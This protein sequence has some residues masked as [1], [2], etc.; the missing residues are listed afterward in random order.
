MHRSRI[1]RTFCRIGLGLLPLA[2]FVILRVIF[3]GIAGAA[4]L[5]KN[6]S[7][8]NIAAVSV[9]LAMGI[10]IA[11]LYR[12]EQT[13][14][15][16]DSPL[17]RYCGALIT[18]GALLPG[19]LLVITL[20]VYFSG[21]ENRI[22]HT[23]FW[24]SAIS[25]WLVLVSAYI[26]RRFVDAQHAIPSSYDEFQRRF[27]Q[28]K[29]VFQTLCP[30]IPGDSRGQLEG[31]DPATTT[32]CR[33]ISCQIDRV[34]KVLERP[35]P[36]WVL[37]TGYVDIW[38]QLY[39][40]EEA[41][42]EI[43]PEEK[44][45]EWAFNDELRLD[46]S[47]IDDKHRQA[48]LSKV[49]RAVADINPNA[50]A[51]LEAPPAETKCLTITTTSPLHDGCFQAS[52]GAPPYTW[53]IEGGAPAGMTWDPGKGVLSGTPKTATKIIVRVKDTKGQ[54]K[55]QIFNL[56]P[57]A[58]SIAPRPP[59]GKAGSKA[60]ARSALRSVRSAID[61]YRGAKWNGLILAR[62]HLLATMFLTTL[63]VYA[64]LA[65]TLMFKPQKCSVF[66]ATIFYMVGMT[67]G[68]SSRLRSE[69]ENKTGVFDYGLTA[70]RLVTVPIFSGLAAICGVVLIAMLPNVSHAFGPSPSSSKETASI[71][72]MSS[73]ETPS[74][75]S[76]ATQADQ[77]QSS[78]MDRADRSEEPVPSLSDIF[79]LRKNLLGLIVAA[80]FGLTPAVVFDR[81]KA[82][83]DKYQS[84]L[85][86]SQPSQGT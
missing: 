21:W 59:A 30:K 80:A 28:A 70:A 61:E 54:M 8:E 16:G 65:I 43:A 11:A 12:G 4:E 57:S 3:I 23:L 51:Y 45:L 50:A 72:R 5:F 24:G 35:G 39:D 6:R 79:N 52:G 56:D 60:I 67:I 84:D 17:R 44:V 7:L 71:S 19:T 83:T 81:L 20:A 77:G 10:L 37:A 9:N 74:V 13:P 36:E 48:L 75:V 41:L 40:I 69:F 64:L 31:Q 25:L 86:S 58:A 42:F 46:G 29:A 14:A 1:L 47:E 76:E 38:S 73:P 15:E 49:R 85:K 27:C 66:A 26:C 33:E 82:L 53:E 32:T 22:Q 55:E 34:D 63:A 18:T 78:S 68:L 62:N 2:S